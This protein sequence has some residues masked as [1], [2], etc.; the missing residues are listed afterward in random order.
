MNPA[1]DMTQLAPALAGAAEIL[2]DPEAFTVRSYAID[3]SGRS[4]E[5]LSDE[6]TAWDVVG[7]V[8]KCLGLTIDDYH[9]VEDPRPQDLPTPQPI[10]KFWVVV[11]TINVFATHR[12]DGEPPDASRRS[13]A[14]A[15][16]R[17]LATLDAAKIIDCRTATTKWK[18]WEPI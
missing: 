13:L 2:S 6:A 18:R 1:I 14:V 12:L 11:T 3:G 4:V 8:L 10:K 15:W 17:E 7:A 9:A 16:L 5:P